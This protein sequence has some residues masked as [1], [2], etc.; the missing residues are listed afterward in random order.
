MKKI[1]NQCPEIEDYIVEQINRHEEVVAIGYTTINLVRNEEGEMIPEVISV[2][3]ED[4]S[5]TGQVVAKP[6]YTKRGDESYRG[7]CTLYTTVYKGSYDSSLK[8]YNFSTHSKVSWSTP[9][10][11]G[12]ENYHGSGWDYS[13]CKFK[14][15]IMAIV[16][17]CKLY[18]FNI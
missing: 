12:G 5:L 16:F 18:G 4:F 15:K 2:A 14:F 6:L 9:V 1:I 3:Q 13:C 7:M 8:Q 17:L 10:W 11:L